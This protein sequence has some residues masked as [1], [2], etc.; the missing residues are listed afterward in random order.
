MSESRCASSP[1]AL[2]NVNEA[3]DGRQPPDQVNSGL[4]VRRKLAAAVRIHH[5]HLLLL[6]SP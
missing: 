1:G 5:R 3:P 2:M 4:Y 6:L